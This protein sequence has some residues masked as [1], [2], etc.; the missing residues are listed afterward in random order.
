MRVFLVS[1]TAFRVFKCFF[2]F[3]VRR[4]CPRIFEY[5]IAEGP[6]SLSKS[7][8]ILSII[9]TVPSDV[10]TTKFLRSATFPE[11]GNN[12]I[13]ITLAQAGSTATNTEKASSD[14]ND[15]SAEDNSPTNN[16][17]SPSAGNDAPTYN[18]YGISTGN[19]APTHNNYGVSTGNDAPTYDNYGSSTGNYYS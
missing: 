2:F 1:S 12:E 6:R 5:H 19:D 3:S 16:N 8:I 9:Q 11:T 18:N 10:T 15:F 17:G 13:A 4:F 14:N 7:A